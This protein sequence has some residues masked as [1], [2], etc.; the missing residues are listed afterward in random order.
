M[1]TARVANRLLSQRT[2]LQS[3]TSSAQ[4]STYSL[5]FT[6]CNVV[7]PGTHTYIS[8]VFNTVF[9]WQT[10][11]SS[12]NIC[13]AVCIHVIL[14]SLAP[15][16]DIHHLQNKFIF[17]FSSSKPRGWQPKDVFS[18]KHP[19]FESSRSRCDWQSVGPYRSWWTI[20]NRL[21]K[22]RVAFFLSQRFPTGG[23]WT[24]R[25]PQTD[26]RDPCW[27]LH[28]WDESKRAKYRTN[29]RGGLLCSRL[30]KTTNRAQF[31]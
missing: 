18:C 3:T 29:R 16:A 22:W 15:T 21:T 12:C 17:L 19:G 25:G 10:N 20:A 28:V 1:L 13:T 26:F 4:R 14:R 23:P 11:F 27:P 24:P 9:V 31:W 6:I 8:D 2:V 7:C 5:L 30:Q